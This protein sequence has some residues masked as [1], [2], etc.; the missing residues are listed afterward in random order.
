MYRTETDSQIS[1]INQQLPM[2]RGKRGEGQDRSRGLKSTNKT[3]VQTTMCKT[4]YN[5]G[6]IA[7]IL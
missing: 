7:S 2:G 4:N 5:T 3:E 6:Y 1:R